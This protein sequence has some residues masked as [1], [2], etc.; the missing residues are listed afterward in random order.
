M[1]PV[2]TTPSKNTTVVRVH[3]GPSADGSL[4]DPGSTRQAVADERPQPEPAS[5]PDAK[6]PALTL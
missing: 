3:G 1:P 5:R 6:R 2:P 4:S